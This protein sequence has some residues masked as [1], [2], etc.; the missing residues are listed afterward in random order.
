MD[1][2]RNLLLFQAVKE[3]W[4]TVKN[5]QSY[6]HKF[7]VLLFWTQCIKFSK[8]IRSKVMA[9]FCASIMQTCDTDLRLFHFKPGLQVICDM[10]N[11]PDNSEFPGAFLSS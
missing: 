10:S 2:V 6:Y 8:E 9:P 1:F 5:W 11:H 4:K 3:F 7:G